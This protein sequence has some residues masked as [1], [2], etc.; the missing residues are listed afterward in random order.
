MLTALGIRC[1]RFRP[2]LPNRACREELSEKDLSCVVLGTVLCAAIYFIIPF[3][4]GAQGGVCLLFPP[5]VPRNNP[6]RLRDAGRGPRW[7]F[8][9]G[10]PYASST[11]IHQPCSTGGERSRPPHLLSVSPLTSQQH[12]FVR[13]LL[14]RGGLCCLC[15]V[16]AEAPSRQI[17]HFF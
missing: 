11:C 17:L 8:E 4:P 10:P 6:V 5:F 1:R 3:L 14:S 13:R 7:G 16:T 12:P 15:V 9:T 2:L